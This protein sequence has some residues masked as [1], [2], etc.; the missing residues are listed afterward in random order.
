MYKGLKKSGFVKKSAF[1]PNIERKL[2]I[3]PPTEKKRKII[4]TITTTEI[5]F[6]AYKM[7]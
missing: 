2:L 1:I 5:K 3:G 6:G 4:P 7:S